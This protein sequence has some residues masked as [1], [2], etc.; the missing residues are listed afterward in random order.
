MTMREWTIPG[1]KPH[2][3]H[4]EHSPFF[5]GKARILVDGQEIYRRKYS[6]YD[7]GFEHRFDLDGLPAIVRALYR[8]W[9]YQYELWVDGKLK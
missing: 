3:V 7:T 9:H 5:L 8:T 6:L 4:V 2:T 1:A